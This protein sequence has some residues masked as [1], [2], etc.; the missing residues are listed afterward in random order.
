LIDLLQKDPDVISVQEAADGVS[1][2]KAI[3]EIKPDILFLDVQMPGL[4]GLGVI[5]AI[6][7]D[8][9]PLTVFVKERLAHH[10]EA[11]TQEVHIGPELLKLV[12]QRSR[13]GELWEW[14]P[15][16]TR[17]GIRLIKADEIDW[18]EAAGVY[19]TVHAGGQE[20]LYRAGL[21]TFAERL[22]PFQFVRIHRSSI[23]NLK[24][25]ATLSR[26]SH[27][28][29]DVLLKCGAELIMSRTYRV[30]VEAMLGQTL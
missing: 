11:P 7:A 2:I 14:I 5:E 1:A 15:V 3:T 23:V 4:D 19:V 13:P 30:Q 8:Q 24:S 18:V 6:G 20:F 17:D 28:E 26:R 21:A 22:D 25:I 12:S 27:G 16:R 29:F 9:M 10:R